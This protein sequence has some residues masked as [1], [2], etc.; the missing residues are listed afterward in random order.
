MANFDVDFSPIGNLYNTYKQAQQQATR[1]AALERLRANPNM[2]YDESARML[3][4]GGDIA[5]GS[6]LAS[7]YNQIQQRAL[8]EKQL[9]ETARH[10][11]ATEGLTA[12]G[13]AETS[14]SNRATEAR[15]AE[16][17]A[18]TRRHAGATE[19]QAASTPV[20]IGSDLS[21]DIY[22]VRDPSAPGGF[23]RVDVDQLQPA[24]AVSPPLPPPAE[25]VPSSAKVIGTDEGVRLGLYP[26]GRPGPFDPITPAPAPAPP[27]APAP[28][29]TRAERAALTGDEFLKTLPADMQSLIK[30]VANYEIAPTTFS[31]RGQRERVVAAAKQYNPEF[32]ETDYGNRFLTKKRFSSGPQGNT[33]RSMNVGIDHLA[34]LQEYADA[35]H[36]G[37]VQL[38]NNAK[39]AFQKQFGYDAPTSFNA[40]KAIV[41]SEV[42]K[43]IVGSQGALADREEIKENLRVASSPAQLSGIIKAYKK[44]MAGQVT[45][46]RQQYESTGLKG[47]NK[48]LVPATMKEL[49]LNE[50]GTAAASEAKPAGPV[51]WQT[52]FGKK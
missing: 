20:K 18:E 24:G 31:N 10:A 39:A 46:L 22:A 25:K 48:L 36:N 45:G 40:V 28:P 6:A 3:I 32:E 19:T 37:N 26:P 16:V 38:I 41:G 7:I 35:L 13:Q 9:A 23:R 1:D 30:G 33:L 17:L 44:L 14:R 50:D 34:T 29:R 4:G 15:Q 2:G 21:G 27:A 11:Q 8:A 42:S 5:G 51:D 52:Y 12:T 47:F 43:A 49:G